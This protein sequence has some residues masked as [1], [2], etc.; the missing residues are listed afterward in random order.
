MHPNHSVSTSLQD[1]C[2]LCHSDVYDGPSSSAEGE[3]SPLESSR[4]LSKV[5]GGGDSAAVGRVGSDD[6]QPSPPNVAEA[7]SSTHCVS[8]SSTTLDL[9][10][11]FLG[12]EGLRPLLHTIRVVHWFRI[13]RLS[14]MLLDS[15]GVLDVARLLDGVVTLQE[16]DLS[17]NPGISHVGAKALRALVLNNANLE[18]VRLDGTSVSL[19]MQR[20]IQSLCEANASLPPPARRLRLDVQRRARAGQ[21]MA[22]LPTPMK[23]GADPS[24][25]ALAGGGGLAPGDSAV[26]PLKTS[27][28]YYD[29]HHRASSLPH[30]SVSENLMLPFVPI[31]RN[32]VKRRQQELDSSPLETQQQKHH[33]HQQQHQQ[34]PSSVLLQQQQQQPVLEPLPRLQE[35]LDTFDSQQQQN[36]MDV[37]FRLTESRPDQFHVGTSGGCFAALDVLREALMDTMLDC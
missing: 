30:R 3:P 23:S 21:P 32:E 12:S 31:P 37:I 35:D 10:R 18:R 6:H 5:S 8:G 36:G 24:S 1:I 19:A 28:Y 11:N 4:A 14:H 22:S 17:F 29:E 33:P 15:R 2:L 13:L 7:P 26:S 16:L 27:D 20:E 25:N 9:S 34:T